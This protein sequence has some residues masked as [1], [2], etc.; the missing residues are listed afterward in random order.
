MDENKDLLTILEVNENDFVVNKEVDL[1]KLN[2]GQLRLGIL[3]ALGYIEGS[4]VVRMNVGF[5]V[6]YG[7]KDS[8]F[9]FSIACKAEL[10]GWKEM[11]HKELDVRM[12]P[13]VEKLLSYCYAYLGGALKQHVEGTSLAKFY[14]PVI[15]AKELMPSLIVKELTA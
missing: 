11:S 9:S 6:I 15:E 8:L 3:S 12:N 7:E 13:A 1:A 4:N 14:L 10:N 2:G 5:R